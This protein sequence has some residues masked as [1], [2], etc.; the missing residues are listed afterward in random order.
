MKNTQS[1]IKPIETGWKIGTTYFLGC[2]DCTHNFKRQEIKMRNKVLRE[3]LI[4]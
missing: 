3:K 2:E 1:R 4:N